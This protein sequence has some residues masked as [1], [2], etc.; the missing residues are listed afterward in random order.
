M[1]RADDYENTFSA[2][3]TNRIN[4]YLTELPDYDVLV[5]DTKIPK[6]TFI[7]TAQH[8]HHIGEQLEGL[9]IAEYM[10]H[11]DDGNA[12]SFIET[13]TIHWAANLP[14]VPGSKPSFEKGRYLYL[15]V[16]QME[17]S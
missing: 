13:L 3:N 17:G 10:L 15:L 8:P 4:Q 9:R 11:L 7:S 1:K 2:E 16:E 12:Q 5:Q 14:V 6:N